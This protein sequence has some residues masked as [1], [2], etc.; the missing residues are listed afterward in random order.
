MA[1]V[2]E[3]GSSADVEAA[4]ARMRVAAA[5]EGIG[6]GT[7]LGEFVAAVGDLARH[8]AATVERVGR[9]LRDASAQAAEAAQAQARK[10]DAA[11]R[12]MEA[13]A[14]QLHVETVERLTPAIA[15][16]VRG[17]VVIRERRHNRAANA[18]SA[19]GLAT[20]ALALVVG[21]WRPRGR[22]DAPALDLRERCLR[23][24]VKDPQGRLY[25]PVEAL[26]DGPAAAARR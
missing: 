5:R 20:L 1:A 24:T 12:G 16:A 6:P 26:R 19:F 9:D 18:A 4:A 25:C 22:A 13:R 8:L 10:L 21:G 23:E 17:A 11:V 3:D 14:A 7:P 2:I 15:E